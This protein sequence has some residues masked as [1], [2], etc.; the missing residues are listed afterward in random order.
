MILRS[1]LTTKTLQYTNRPIFFLLQ[2]IPQK[3]N[4]SCDKVM[5]WVVSISHSF[6][7]RKKERVSC[8]SL[9]IIVVSSNYRRQQQHQ[10]RHRDHHHLQGYWQHPWGFHHHDVVD[11]TKFFCISKASKVLMPALHLFRLCWRTLDDADA[12]W[13]R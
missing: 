6:H 9:E 12:H 5:N 7:H 2:W 11:V 4:G 13:S 1:G 8:L 10:R 3:L